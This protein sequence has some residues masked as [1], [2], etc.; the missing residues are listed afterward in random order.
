M[1][2]WQRTTEA[3]EQLTHTHTHTSE[4]NLIYLPPLQELTPAT[5]GG[6]D[7]LRL[8]NLKMKK[9]TVR[10]N[11]SVNYS[12]NTTIKNNNYVNML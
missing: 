6:E 3:W 8:V 11:L 5:A 1:E 12:C 9:K 10:V 4:G 7:N 2:D